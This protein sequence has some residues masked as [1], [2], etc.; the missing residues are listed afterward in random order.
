M[1]ELEL[2][3][4]ARPQLA[5][6]SHTHEMLMNWLIVNPEKSMRECADHFGYTQ[7]W[8]SS[9]VHSDLFQSAL[10][11]KQMAVQARVVA[12][13]PERLRRNAEIGLEKLG[14]IMEKCEDGEFILD[15][16]DKMLHRMGYAPQ[17]ARNP[18]GSPGVQNQ[19]NNFYISAGDLQEARALIGASPAAE[20]PVLPGPL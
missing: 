2:L 11:D 20:V 18:A 3:P 14:D 1:E 6:L 8:L 17:S 12:S 19:Q 16:T 9:I 15:A 13:I 4:A 5:R 7:S 10:R